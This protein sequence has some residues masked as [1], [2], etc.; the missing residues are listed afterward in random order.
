M[1]FSHYRDKDQVEVDLVI[2]DGRKVWGVEVKKS[3]SIQ[4]KDGVGLARLASLSGND[5]Q[6]GILLYTGNNC[7]PINQVPNTYAVPMDAL[8]EE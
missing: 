4:P 1:H 8:W 7:L 6:G 5:W 3:A 2:E